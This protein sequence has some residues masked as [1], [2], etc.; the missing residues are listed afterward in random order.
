M[1]RVCPKCNGT[2]IYGTSNK[3]YK[4]YTCNG[5]GV[6][7]DKPQPIAMD[8]SKLFAAFEAAQK[9]HYPKPTLRMRGLKFKGSMANE[10]FDRSILVL[11]AAADFEHAMLGRIL[12]DGRFMPNAQN[13]DSKW[14]L[15]IVACVTNPAEE[16]V[17]YG[18]G[19]A[20]CS[21]CG[22]DLSNPESIEIGI[23]PICRARM[24]WTPKPVNAS[25]GIDLSALDAIVKD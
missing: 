15:D 13:W 4:C 12:A 23:G 20:V 3:N 1:N 9:N 16:A 6:I 25:V 7:K 22:R 8:A 18:L 10:Q 21:V 14:Y 19:H 5:T 17:K 24:G 11:D 2:G